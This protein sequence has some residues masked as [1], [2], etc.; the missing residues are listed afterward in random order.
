LRSESRI[1]QG[2]AD[3]VDLCPAFN[4]LQGFRFDQSDLFVCG[5]QDVLIHCYAIGNS[6]LRLGNAFAQLGFE[7]N[8]GYGDAVGFFSLEERSCDLDCVCCLSQSVKRISACLFC[9]RWASFPLPKIKCPPC[10][11]PL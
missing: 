9:C 3:V 10:L 7:L 6:H 4:C 11:F 8:I 5:L 1:L 2:F